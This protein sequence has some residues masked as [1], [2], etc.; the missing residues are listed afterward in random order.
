MP[1]EEYNQNVL[2]MRREARHKQRPSR[3]KEA[4]FAPQ[5]QSEDEQELEEVEDEVQDE[6]QQ[7]A[8]ED[9]GVR[10]PWW[11]PKWPSLRLVARRPI[12][13]QGRESF[14]AYLHVPGPCPYTGCQGTPQSAVP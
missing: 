9:D 6:A 12:P 11:W 7:E 10:A 5:Q 4:A 3:L 2:S 14:P 1:L 13:V 8:E